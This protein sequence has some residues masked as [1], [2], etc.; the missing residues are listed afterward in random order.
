M[1]L[2][3][4]DQYQFV[5]GTFVRE[6][7]TLGGDVSKFVS[8]SVLER[9]QQRVKRADP[10]RPAATKRPIHGPAD[11][12]RMH[13]LRCLR[14]RVPEPGD[15]D[16]RVDLRDRPAQVHRVRR[17]LRRA[18]VRAGLPGGLH[19]G[20]PGERRVPRDAVGEVPA[21]A[22]RGRGR[23]PRLMASDAREAPTGLGPGLS[24]PS[25]RWRRSRVP[26]R[27]RRSSSASWMLLR[28]CGW[29][30]RGDARRAQRAGERRPG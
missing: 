11:H 17:P 28:A 1:F 2:T 3:P 12:R 13:Q 23:D 25:G 24:S 6:I 9:L 5:S 29:R 18:A 15:L 4:S 26:R 22:G 27:S 16:G 7:A 21:P 10:R 8:P 19:P 14:A 20:R 30:R